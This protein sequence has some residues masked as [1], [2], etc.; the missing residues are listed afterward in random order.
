M[1]IVSARS[2]RRSPYRAPTRS[3]LTQNGR[4]RERYAV[5]YGAK[6]KAKQD[7]KVKPRVVLVD[8]GTDR[9]RARGRT[10]LHQT[11]SLAVYGSAKAMAPPAYKLGDLVATREAYGTAL[12]KLGEADARVVALL[13][14]HPVGVV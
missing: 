6:I 8:F 4:E 13:V 7:Q 5:V 11:G 1:T 3:S 9:L 10:T 2:P 14:G 12:A